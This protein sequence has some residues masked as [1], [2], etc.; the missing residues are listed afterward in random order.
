MYSLGEC[1]KFSK[2]QITLVFVKCYII[3]KS[4]SQK[5]SF[6]KSLLAFVILMLCVKKR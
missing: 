1:K 4:C 5:E 6:T 3:L 2:A